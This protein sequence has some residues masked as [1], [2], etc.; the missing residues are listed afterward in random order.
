ML[1]YIVILITFTLI[2][3]PHVCLY[4]FLNSKLSATLNTSGHKKIPSRLCP[5]H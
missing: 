1:L 2:P 4:S 5:P 3:V